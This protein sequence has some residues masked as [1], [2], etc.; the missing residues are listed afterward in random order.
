MMKSRLPLAQEAISKMEDIIQ[1]DRGAKCYMMP[2]YKYFVWK[3]LSKGIKQGN[4]LDIGTGSGLLAIELA[5]STKDRSINITALDISSNM[6]K[7]AVENAREADVANRIKF[8]IGTAA[9][10]PFPNEYF[11]AV[12]SYASL[13]HWLDP[14][15]VFNEVARVIKKDGIVIIRDNRRVYQDLLWKCIIWMIS[16]LMNKRHRENWPKAILASYTIP[17]IKTILSQTGLKHCKI[18]SDFVF[19]DLCIETE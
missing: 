12:I 2:E 3:L 7:K 1:Y 19:I 6:I 9:D 15:A 10:L 5:K 14:V 18:G 13:H 16:R 11:D 17:E 4:V 8:V